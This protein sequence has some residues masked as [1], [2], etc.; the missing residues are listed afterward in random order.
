MISFLNQPFP[1]EYNPKQEWKFLLLLT[2]FPGLFF[3][4]FKPFGIGANVEDVTTY[5]IILGF[6]LITAFFAGV[7]GLILP[8]VLKRAY[9]N[10]T[11]GKAIL[12]YSIMISLIGVGN[13]FYKSYWQ[14]FAELSWEA[15]FIVFNRT[16]VLAII[17]TAAIIAW[18]QNH[19]LKKHLQTALEFNHNLKEEHSAS[20]VIISAENNKEQLRIPAKELL[21]IVNQDNY[22]M[23]YYRSQENIHKKL[24][25]TTLK[26][27]ESQINHPKLIRCHRSYIVNL[28]AV[29]HVK[30]NSRGLQ[31]NI[32]D[33]EATVPV[34]R[35]Y[36][37]KVQQQL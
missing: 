4:V 7:F 36:I 32:D 10:F 22:V 2:L 34:S 27:V 37:Q 33:R 6:G 17:P 23:V 31:L 9:L 24:I 20:E 1:F 30:G 21:Y 5:L 25:R 13:F 29:K 8:L 28:N 35:S 18:Y 15:F 26:E 14:D 12:H 19:L 3:I 16:L 11:I